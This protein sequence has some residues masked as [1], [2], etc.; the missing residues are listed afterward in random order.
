[1]IF[2]GFG[3][4]M[5]SLWPLSNSAFNNLAC[6]GIP[7]PTGGIYGVGV[8]A[9]SVHEEAT[10]QRFSKGHCF[11]FFRLCLCTTQRSYR[12][13][14]LYFNLTLLL[15]FWLVLSLN[16]KKKNYI[17][18]KQCMPVCMVNFCINTKILTFVLFHEGYLTNTK[19]CNEV[20][21]KMKCCLPSSKC[22]GQCIA[23]YILFYWTLMT[24]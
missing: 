9:I 5:V 1:M 8:R 7:A 4:L 17:L 2:S 14:S 22:S 16:V 3:W 10:E 21:L 23:A 20:E 13:Q 12:K 19:P 11:T 24:G 18:Y 15:A 6:Q